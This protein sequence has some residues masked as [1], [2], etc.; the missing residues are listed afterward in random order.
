MWKKLALKFSNLASTTI[1]N[2]RGDWTPNSSFSFSSEPRSADYPVYLT[3]LVNIKVKISVPF[4]TSS[5][6]II[7]SGSEQ[8]IHKLQ[9]TERTTQ[10]WKRGTGSASAQRTS[11]FIYP[12]QQNFG[13]ET[14]LNSPEPLL[15]LQMLGQKAT[16]VKAQLSKRKAKGNKG[17]DVTAGYGK[18]RNG[19][20]V[21]GADTRRTFK[22]LQERTKKLQERT[23]RKRPSR[24]TLT[25]L[26]SIL[27]SV[28]LFIVLIEGG[29]LQPRRLINWD[30]WM[31]L[32]I[33]SIV[34]RHP[35]SG[36]V[37]LQI[38]LM[39]NLRWIRKKT[40]GFS[41]WYNK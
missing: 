9:K 2:V 18:L 14:Q 30:L 3:I 26:G 35:L 39:L 8:R 27:G 31:K 16:S 15:L 4:V 36:T 7:F 13:R 19:E 29:S 34:C 28:V 40:I 25:N 23:S 32:F 5:F 21:V 17:L 41:F 33:E 10:T 12:T 22:K 24:W 38:I 37:R 1:L 20:L 6:L 11:L